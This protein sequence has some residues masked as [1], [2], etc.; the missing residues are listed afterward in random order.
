MSSEHKQ[1]SVY[2]GNVGRR[3]RRAGK[4]DTLLR[5]LTPPSINTHSG[6]DGMDHFPRSLSEGAP[7]SRKPA[8]EDPLCLT[9]G[10][11]EGRLSGVPSGR[12]PESPR[13]NQTS[14]QDGDTR[15]WPR[16]WRKTGVRHVA[17]AGRG[18][19]AGAGAT[20]G[21]ARKP[22]GLRLKATWMRKPGPG[23]AWS[24]RMLSSLQEEGRRPLAPHG[25]CLAASWPWLAWRRTESAR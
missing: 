24:L 20:R 3:P 7:G 10:L 23:S 13:P 9:L 18:A 5:R 1:A 19:D 14:E 17:E 16:T 11:A 21:W 25:M 6:R 15:R 4:A 22:A 12:C 8:C 2:F